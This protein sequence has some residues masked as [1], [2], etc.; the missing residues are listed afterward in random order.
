MF[1]TFLLLTAAL[2][3]EKRADALSNGDVRELFIGRP[4]GT[5]VVY[6]RLDRETP[7]DR[8][9]GLG[10]WM[11]TPGRGFGEHRSELEVLLFEEETRF[12]H[13]ETV[14][15]GERRLIW[16][17]VRPR[18]GR[19]V[20]AAGASSSGFTIL[21]NVGGEVRR[22]TTNAE[23]GILPLELVEAARRGE[24]F[25]GTFQVFQPLSGGFEQLLV[26][27]REVEDRRGERTRELSLRQPD[28]TQR[29]SYRFRRGELVE[30]AWTAGGPRARRISEG[31]YRERL[32]AEA[33]LPEERTSP[34]P[35]PP[36][37]EG[38]NPPR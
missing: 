15:P 6:F 36:S 7:G 30:F 24:D 19:T 14:L 12:S 20:T 25:L 2:A 27:T 33:P 1:R 37:L 11:R 34:L 28:G 3:Q 13:V 8:P 26:D 22:A 32:A 38:P 16:R 18:S 17:E 5:Q 29:A 35:T 31:E 10:R 9:L 4:P 21:D 23:R